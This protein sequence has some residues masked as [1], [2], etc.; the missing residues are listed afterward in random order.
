MPAVECR[1]AVSRVAVWLR[2][3]QAKKVQEMGC[4]HSS[5][6]ANISLD[7]MYY[8]PGQNLIT[9]D[10][11][12]EHIPSKELKYVTNN[13]VAVMRAGDEC[14][15]VSVAWLNTWL[16]YVKG[17]GS[18]PKAIDNKSLIDTQNDRKMRRSAVAKKEYRP[19]CKAVWEFYFVAYGGGPV[20]LFHGD[21]SFSPS[22]MLV[23]S[24]WT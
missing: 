6:S 14:Y 5:Q 15:V 16:D 17:K 3:C 11:K 13:D 19:V 24:F 18:I 2:Y 21:L 9:F 20:I 7:Q 8:D 10:P 12:Y 4:L 1:V 23:S 22:L